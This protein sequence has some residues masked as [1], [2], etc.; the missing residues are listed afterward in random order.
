M[1]HFATLIALMDNEYVTPA[2]RARIMRLAKIVARQRGCSV[3]DVLTA[4]A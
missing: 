1:N 3:A 2:N 4:A